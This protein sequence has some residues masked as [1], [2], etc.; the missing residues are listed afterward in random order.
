MLKL[1]YM[2]VKDVPET[3]PSDISEYRKEKILSARRD[4][5]K[6]LMTAAA[7]VLKAGFASFGVQERDVV[8]STCENG[9]PYALSHPDIYFSLSH[10]QT[11]AVAVF[12]DAPVGVDC[13]RADRDVP[14]ELVRRFLH[15]RKNETVAEPLLM[16]VAGESVS[17][18]SGLGILSDKAKS[19]ISVFSG[20][21]ASCGDITLEKFMLSDNLVVVSTRSY[22]KAE[23]I[24]V[25]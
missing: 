18:L 23:I 11:M 7:L 13:E 12:S 16:W 17:K 4:E 15:L 24:G 2:S 10:S 3:I 21:V 5:A 9:K 8:Y 25:S 22:E 6:R 19:H 14:A 1:F 20:N